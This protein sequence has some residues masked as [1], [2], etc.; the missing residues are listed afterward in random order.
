MYSCG[1]PHPTRSRTFSWPCSCQTSVIFRE[2]PFEL[3]CSWNLPREEERRTGGGK[4]CKLTQRALLARAQGARRLERARRDGGATG[5]A[6]DGEA[7]D[8]A[9]GG[10]HGRRLVSL[11][12]LVFFSSGVV[13][14]GE[15]RRSFMQESGGGGNLEAIEAADDSKR[16][17]VKTSFDTAQ[18]SAG[19]L[20][21]FTPKDRGSDQRNK[22]TTLER[23]PSP[24]KHET[25]NNTL[26]LREIDISP[27]HPLI[28]GRKSEVR[29]KDSFAST[30]HRTCGF[31]SSPRWSDGGPLPCRTTGYEVLVHLS[32][33]RNGKRRA[34]RRARIWVDDGDGVASTLRHRLM[35]LRV[36]SRLEAGRCGVECVGSAREQERRRRVHLVLQRRADRCRHA[37]AVLTKIPSHPPSQSSRQLPSAERNPGVAALEQASPWGCAAGSCRHGGLPER[38]PS[39][40]GGIGVGHGERYAAAAAVVVAAADIGTGSWPWLDVAREEDGDGMN[41]SCSCRCYAGFG[42]RLSRGADHNKG[43]PGVFGWQKANGLRM[44]TKKGARTR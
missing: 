34:S 23:G 7:G 27:G 24:A 25:R 38:T 19:D 3:L 32:S 39:D 31:S 43:R 1:T 36:M 37:Q 20:T 10:G 29:T 18:Q 17:Y 5:G 30:H 6:A 2:N 28:D 13:G 35:Q 11:L 15:G 41:A 26:R 44:E 12:F 9:R 42:R 4:G 33:R 14:G 21:A 8:E 22:T 16:C 40:H